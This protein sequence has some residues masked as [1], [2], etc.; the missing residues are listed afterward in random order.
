MYESI[1]NAAIPVC[2]VVIGMVGQHYLSRAA[3]HEDTAR[4]KRIESYASYLASTCKLAITDQSRPDEQENARMALAT[5][6]AHIAVHGSN[7]VVKALAKFETD[8]LLATSESRV[9]F[10]RIIEAMRTDWHIGSV[11]GDELHWIMFSEPQQS[12]QD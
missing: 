1:L 9:A 3:R 12:T 8:P 11:S 10:I 2:S 7:D 6:K 4:D 5:A